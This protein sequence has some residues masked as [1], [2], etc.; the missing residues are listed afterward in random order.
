[1]KIRIG[2]PKMRPLMVLLVVLLASIPASGQIG[3][4]QYLFQGVVLDESGSPAPQARVLAVYSRDPYTRRETTTDENGRWRIP[5]LSKGKDIWSVQAFSADRMS[6]PTEI[7]IRKPTTEMTLVLAL[8]AQTPLVEAKKSIHRGEFEIAVDRLKWFLE[9]FPG[10]GA[11]SQAR[12]WMGYSLNR[13]SDDG[14]EIQARKKIKSQA[15]EHLET[16]LRLE[17]EG[18]WA[19]DARILRIEIALFLAQH[20]EESGRAIIVKEAEAPETAVADV[21]LAALDALSKIA[22]QRAL[23]EMKTLI[24]QSAD[25]QIRKKAVLLVGRWPDDSLPDFLREI[26]EKDPDAAVREAARFGLAIRKAPFRT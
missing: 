9:H 22:P 7:L 11:S 23:A 12:F 8:S 18:E 21:R 3:R 4:G 17:P 1:M 20:D 26:A 15:I 10:H 13:L 24:R 14:G 19:D 25:P 5:F 16:L 2:T 6:S